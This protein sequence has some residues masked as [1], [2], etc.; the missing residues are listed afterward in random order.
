MYGVFQYGTNTYGTASKD[1]IN[2]E[3][4]YIE[5]MDYL[6]PIYHEIKEMKSLQKILGNKVG[7]AV[8]DTENLLEQCFVQTAT[9]GLDRWEKE[10]GLP[11]DQSK[12]YEQRREIL[13]AKLRGTG[14]TT[15][16]MIKNVASAFSGGDVEVKE[17]PEEYRFVVQ[18]VGVKGIPPNMSGLIGAIE[19]IKPAHLTYSFKYTF[20]TWNMIDHM[21]WGDANNKTWGELKIYEGDE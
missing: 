20:T 9:W 7:K 12:S 15:K 19:E 14:T 4:Y 13:L 16:E 10:Y 5:F 1:M 8:Y 11:T 2:P 3:D 17:F 21:T 6:P 18:F